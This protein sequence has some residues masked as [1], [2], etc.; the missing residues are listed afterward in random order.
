MEKGSA[1]GA[2]GF[3]SYEKVS[4]RFFSNADYRVRVNDN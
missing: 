4:S 2:E 3:G 1:A